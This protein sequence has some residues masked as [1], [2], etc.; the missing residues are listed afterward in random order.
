TPHVTLARLR[1][2]APPAVAAY[3][4]ARGYFPSLK[5]EAT[6]FVLYSSRDSVGGGPYIIEAEYPLGRV[7]LM[8]RASGSRF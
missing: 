4:G 1:G 7:E 3:L 8:A 5:F 6:R 2:A